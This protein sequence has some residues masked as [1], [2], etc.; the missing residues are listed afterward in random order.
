MALDSPT[1]PE[2]LRERQRS[3]E[4]GRGESP[5]KTG[6]GLVGAEPRVY[7]GDAAQQAVAADWGIRR[8]YEIW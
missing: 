3:R 6:T 4:R 2:G 8:R 5:G 7:L 1:V